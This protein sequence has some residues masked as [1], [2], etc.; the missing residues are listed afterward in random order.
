MGVPRG[1]CKRHGSVSDPRAVPEE[2]SPEG[3]AS[4]EESEDTTENRCASDGSEDA[5]EGS[6]AMKK[7]SRRPSAK[8]RPDSDRK[9]Q[10]GSDSEENAYTPL[11]KSSPHL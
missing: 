4:S 2:R 6:S 10:S 1:L 11:N 3:S 9:T 5:T 7:P 8:D